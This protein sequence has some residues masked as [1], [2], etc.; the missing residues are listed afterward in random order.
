MKQAIWGG[1]ANAAASATM[2]I[3]FALDPI[4]GSPSVLQIMF[5]YV[6]DA[7]HLLNTDDF[8]AELILSDTR[9]VNLLSC[10]APV[11][12]TRGSFS[13]SILFS[14]LAAA[15]TYLNF[16]LVEGPGDGSSAVGLDNLVVNAI[17]EPGILALMGLGLLG[18]GGMRFKRF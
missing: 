14:S 10:D 12:A 3:Q 7:N 5:D 11:A 15:P 6:F 4:A 1:Q 9:I 18:L 2:S 13:T 16:R 17:S 8:V